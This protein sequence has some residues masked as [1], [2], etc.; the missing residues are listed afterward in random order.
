MARERPGKPCPAAVSDAVGLEP[1]PRYLDRMKEARDELVRI[2]DQGVAHPIG[3]IASQRLRSRTGAYRM[4]PAPGHVVFMRFTGEDGRRDAEDGAVVR[5][6]GEIAAPGAMCEVFALLGHAGW[7]GELAVLDGEAAR[8]VYF[9]QGMVV[10]VQT[11]VEDERIGNV[12]YRFG[13]ISGD[14][15]EQI[16]AVVR[17]GKRYGAAA[18]ELGILQ[19]DQVY[20]HLAKQI[21]EVVFSILT[22]DDGTFFFLDGFDEGR[23]VARQTISANAL[24]MDAVTRMDEIRYF[25]E[26][27]PSPDY[28]PVR[29]ETSR[30]PEEEYVAIHQAVDGHRSVEEI[31]RVTGRGVFETTKALYALTQSKHVIMHPPPMTGGLGAVVATANEALRTLHRRADDNALGEDLRS[32]LSSF[33]VGA[34]V[35]QILFRGAGPDAQGLLDPDKVESNL[36]LLLHGED[37]EQVLKQMLHDYVGFAVFSLGGMMGGDE[38][39][40]ITDLV[41]DLLSR[42]RPCA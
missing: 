41:G 9:D 13:V 38:E 30:T 14:Q 21:Q 3:G 2:D 31:G 12:L 24:L 39:Q 27:I 19:Q 26:K 8:S 10:G 23:L 35:Y 29:I 5:L 34:G 18:V 7:R 42:L 40:A 11:N 33:A 15:H 25:E 36:A 1:A 22:V 16:L 32:S 20:S 6:A 28:V 17:T 37:P 4:L